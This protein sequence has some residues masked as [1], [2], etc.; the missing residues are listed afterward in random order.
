MLCL[1]VFLYFQTSKIR[2]CIILG[3][4][5]FYSLRSLQSIWRN[6][7]LHVNLYT[8]TLTFVSRFLKDTALPMMK[9]IRQDAK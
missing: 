3:L 2:C 6:I 4:H 7:P 1:L 5:L 9:R 8:N